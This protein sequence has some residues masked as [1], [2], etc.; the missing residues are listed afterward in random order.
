MLVA[1]HKH[2]TVAEWV[3]F[4]NAKPEVVPHVAASA[5]TSEADFVKLKATELPDAQF[6][7]SVEP[8][9][10]TR[11]GVLTRVFPCLPACLLACLQEI[12]SQT[13]V[14]VI[15]LD[16]A[17]GYSQHFVDTVKKAIQPP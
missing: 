10:R 13:K 4:C 2:Y 5:G 12:L 9:S 1:V 17:N 15:C 14:R 7:P 6:L 11:P 16:I 8:Y 3:A